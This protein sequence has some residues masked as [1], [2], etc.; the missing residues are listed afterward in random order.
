M[1]NFN[2][3]HLH[4]GLW[5]VSVTVLMMMP[6]PA[7]PDLGSWLPP[8]LDQWIDKIQHL[9]A[10]MV[11]VVLVARSLG[12]LESVQRPVSMAA[13]LTLGFSFILEALQALVPW[14]LF[15]VMDL[16]A[17]ALGV[18]IALPIAKRYVELTE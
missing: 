1:K 8:T 14:R 5:I 9:L 16:V 3:P 18:L 4:A 12:E 6:A 7:L 15:E 17:D 13:I 2:S 10:F 11:M